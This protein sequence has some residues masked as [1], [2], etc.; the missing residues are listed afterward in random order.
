MK[1]LIVANWKCNPTSQK[2]AKHLFDS[3]KRGLSKT[4]AKSEIV[5]CPPFVYLPLFQ[6]TSMPFKLG[7][8]NCFFEEKGAFTGEISPLMLKDLGCQY[9]ILGHSERRK[10]GEND[11]AI[12]LKIKKCLEVSLIPI[13]CVGESK[14]EKNQGKRFSVLEKQIKSALKNIPK[15][16]VE[17]IIIAYEPVWA[18]GTQKPC[19][20]KDLF[21]VTLF[22]QRILSKVIKNP[23]KVGRVKLLYGGSVNSQNA[24]TYLSLKTISGL[25]VGG[26]S[27]DTEEFLKIV[28]VANQPF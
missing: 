11:K 26:A 15:N 17:K 25:L 7:A 12:S 1:P 3:L 10:I 24:E 28:K 13:L 6:K 27:L 2:E 16:K 21:T 8:Q 20:E 23:L 18:I 4:K 14:K 22:L 5:V 19:S 9:V